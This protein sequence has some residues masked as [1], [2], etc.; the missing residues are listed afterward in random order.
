MD[1]SE[2]HQFCV[3]VDEFQNFTY[4][5]DFNTLFTQARKYG[6]ATTIA[7][8]ERYGQLGKNQKILGATAAAANKVLFQTTERDAQ[9]LAPGF[10]SLPPQ[11][12]KQEPALAISSRPFWDLVEKGHGN[13]FIQEFVNEYFVRFTRSIEKNRIVLE[14]HRVARQKHQDK[15]TLYRDAASLASLQEREEHLT[16]GMIWY[17]AILCL[18]MHKPQQAR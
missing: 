7:H 13:P 18:R 2:R 9:E 4:S 15:A 1:R 11:E 3:F 10:A 6:I 12:T 14:R 5:D 16:D 17:S 8:Q